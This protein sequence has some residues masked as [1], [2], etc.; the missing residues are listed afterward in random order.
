MLTAS[1]LNSQANFLI[2]RHGAAAR[3]RVL[4]QLAN[5]GRTANS[6]EIRYWKSLLS[7]ITEKLSGTQEKPA[8]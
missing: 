2:S 7:L 8:H 3:H 1:D 6:P 5:V 4:K